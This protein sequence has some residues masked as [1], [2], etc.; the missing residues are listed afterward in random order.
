MAAEADDAP[1][2]PLTGGAVMGSLGRIAVAV[3]GA[4]TTIVIARLLGPAGQGGFAIALNLV[5]LLVSLTTFGVEHGVAYYVSS[6]RWNA[7]EAL[8]TVRRLS[9]L[10][11][12]VA[13]LIGLTIRLVAPSAFA[14]LTVAETVVVLAAM[15]F[16]LSWFYLTYLAVALDRYEAFTI[17]AALQSTIGLVL[18]GAL[19]ALA[20]L[21]GA[22]IGLTISHVVAALVVGVW[23]ARRIHATPGDAEPRQLRRAVG[24]GVKGYAANA[25]HFLAYRMDVFI[26]ASFVGAVAVGHLA[27]AIAV[28]S[29]MWLLPQALSDVL[30]PRVASLTEGRAAG[31][32][33]M[34]QMVE[35]KSM[36]HAV[37]AITVGTLVLAGALAL[38]VVPVYG[39]EYEPAVALGLILL[40]GVALTGVSQILSA[41]IVGRGRPIYSLYAA[42]IMTPLT[43]VLYVVLVPAL[44][45][46]GAALAKTVSYV[47]GFGVTLAFYRRV[48]GSASPALF[49]PTRDELADYVR[50]APLVREKLRSARRRR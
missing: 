45:A 40:P 46:E 24:F 4:L 1:P 16:A 29:V 10:A 25:L 28:T 13:A 18:V 3:T 47:V 7:R 41:T 32:L 15:P 19:G 27:V 44:E 23:A 11:G 49:M 5:V 12:G 35:A 21:S 37:L 39:P 6:G 8:R 14:G 42:L 17:P 36:R 2:R 50:L 26:L 9:L 33:E 48:T 34:R 22:V 20:G 43:V 31:A 38:L 30:F